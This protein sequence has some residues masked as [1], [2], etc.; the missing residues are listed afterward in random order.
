METLIPRIKS[1]LNKFAIEQE[2]LLR[3]DVHEEALSGSLLEYLKKEFADLDFHIDTQY[4][5]RIL[6][7]EIINKQSEFLIAK[8]PVKHRPS[9]WDENQ[10]NIKK[11]ILPDFI[12]HDRTS[13]NSNFLI[14]EVKKSTNKNEE[15]RLW[16]EIKLREMTRRDLNYDYG[17]FIDLKT[18]AD[19]DIGNYYEITLYSNGEIVYKA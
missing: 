12:F 8:L 6:D 19:Y 15:D 7:D 17:L 13:P 10:K 1:L 3:Q 9:S 11:E 14:I 5:K 18:G 2:I 4:N 16:D